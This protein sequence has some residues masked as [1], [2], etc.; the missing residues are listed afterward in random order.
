MGGVRARFAWSESRGL[1]VVDVPSEIASSSGLAPEDRVL[2]VDGEAVEGA[3]YEDVVERLRGPVGTFVTLQVQRA[4]G[5]SS[6]VRLER[7]PYEARFR[8]AASGYTVAEARDLER[9][10]AAGI[11]PPPPDATDAGSSSTN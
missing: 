10:R 3:A 4:D 5:S 11:E 7:V 8:R 2:A 1:R 6:Q 9:R